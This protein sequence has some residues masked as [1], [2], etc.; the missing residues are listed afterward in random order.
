ME[1]SLNE[2]ARWLCTG[3][4]WVFWVCGVWLLIATLYAWFRLYRQRPEWRLSWV[5][6]MK[7]LSC[8]LS[9]FL[10]TTMVYPFTPSERWMNYLGTLGAILTMNLTARFMKRRELSFSQLEHEK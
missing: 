8:P 2:Y 6:A 1:A 9:C 7:D 5:Q 4:F 10:A 3:A